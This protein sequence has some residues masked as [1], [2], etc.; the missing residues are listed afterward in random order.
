M[1]VLNRTEVTQSQDM[2]FIY[3]L[4]LLWLSVRTR[5]EDGDICIPDQLKIEVAYVKSLSPNTLMSQSTA[6]TTPQKRSRSFQSQDQSQDL[7]KKP[8]SMDDEDSSM[9]DEDRRMLDY[10]YQEFKDETRDDNG[11]MPPT[12]SGVEGMYL[13]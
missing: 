1:Y 4:C 11:I 10:V 9:D 13:T 8:K 7:R 12:P 5:S 6:L 3:H 2:P